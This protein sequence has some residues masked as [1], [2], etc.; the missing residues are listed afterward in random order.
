M[1]SPMRSHATDFA[2][3]VHEVSRRVR[4]DDPNARQ[5]YGESLGV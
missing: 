4:F 3:P 1:D 2:V 5:N